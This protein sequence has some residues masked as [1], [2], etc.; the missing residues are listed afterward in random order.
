MN[1]IIRTLGAVLIIGVIAAGCDSVV[2]NT[3]EDLLPEDM[4]NSITSL[5]EDANNCVPTGVGTL[6]ANY[7]NEVPD[8]P[9]DVTCDAGIFFDE[10]ATINGAALNGVT[11]NSQPAQ[12]G[13]VIRGADVDISNSTVVVEADYPGEFIS[14]AYLNGT[15][16]ISRS[17]ISGAHRVGLL[18]RGEASDVTARGNTITGTGAKTSGWAEN[19]VQVDNG[20]VITFRN[21]E[22]ADH[23]WDGESNWASNAIALR[24]NNSS[25]TNNTF[26]DNE[27][28]ISITGNDNSFKANR[29]SSDVV[30]ESSFEFV[31]W[32][33]FVQGSNNDITGNQLTATDGGA[34]IY[35]FPDTES[36][37]N[38]LTGNRISGFEWPIFDGGDDTMEKGNPSV[39]N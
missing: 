2:D 15:G 6:T 16:T 19:G 25:I 12:Y 22:V 33:V 9:F 4:N 35:I 21:N 27:S 20:A 29:T 31:A 32:G 11:A 3:T 34:G 26:T 23:W 10:D 37:E 38:K 14:V 30:S 7:V 8:G 17:D 36:E 24:A 18:V 28:N 39:F 13:I 5:A 1:K